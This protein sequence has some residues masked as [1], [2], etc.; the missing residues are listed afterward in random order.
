M[1]FN[2]GVAGMFVQRLIDKRADDNDVAKQIEPEHQDYHRSKGAVNQGIVDGN[3]DKFG[4]NETDHGQKQ[5]SGNG[6]GKHMGF[7][8]AVPLRR[9]IDYEKHADRNGDEK[10]KTEPAPKLGKVYKVYKTYFFKKRRQDFCKPASG[11]HDRC[12]DVDENKEEARPD[13]A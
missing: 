13:K 10:D 1:E 12:A 11:K 5:R 7:I 3:A 9:V 8:G 2:A 6:S 4:E